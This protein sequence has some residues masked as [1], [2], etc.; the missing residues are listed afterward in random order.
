MTRNVIVLDRISDYIICEILFLFVFL[1]KR[2][3]YNMKKL[4]LSLLILGSILSNRAQNAPEISYDFK[5]ETSKPYPVVDGE[6]YYFAIENGM[7][8]LKRHGDEIIMQKFSTTGTLEEV[9]RK[10]YAD[11]PDSYSIEG[12]EKIGSKHYLF[13]SIYDKANTTEQLFKREFD[14]VGLKFVNNG[15]RIIA[16]SGKLTGSPFG[17]GVYSGLGFGWKFGVVDKFDVMTSF[18]KSKVIIQYRKKPLEKSDAKNH[19]IIGMVVYDNEMNELWNREIEMPY[20]EKK[21]NNLDFTL[22]SE[23]NGYVLALVYNDES[24]KKFIKG[25]LNYHIE[26]I[27][28]DGASGK[29]TTHPIELNG[30]VINSIALYENG[31]NYMTCAGFYAKTKRAENAE[32]I[33]VFKLDKEGNVKDEVAHEIP[34]EVL[35]QYVKAKKADKMKAKE[36]DGKEYDFQNL[37]MRDV[38]FMADGSLAITA[39]QYY[40]ESYTDSKGRTHYT[41]YYNDMLIAKINKDGGLDWMQKL[42]KRQKGSAGRGGMSFEYLYANNSHYLYFFDNVNNLE[43]STDEV[44]K[45]HS[46]GA[47]GFLTAYKVNDETGKVS[48]VSIL[49][50]RAVKLNPNDEEGIPIY[51]VTP[52]KVLRLSPTEFILEAYIK[53]KMDMFIKMTIE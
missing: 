4:I 16:V 53:K 36:E 40:V 39:E 45:F 5:V 23:G 42:G 7:M 32:G 21:M 13:Y 10:T 25:E 20:T 37:V 24:T 11:M 47:G 33:F 46:D 51:Q 27:K 38:L 43:L 34:I 44:P 14:P 18:D 6:K 2:K 48:K 9:D 29:V 50:S 30:K 26:M 12:V 3:L 31:Q 19:D 8:S 28:I 52:G 35:T 49:D 41:Y 22:D 17:G 15:E 1:T